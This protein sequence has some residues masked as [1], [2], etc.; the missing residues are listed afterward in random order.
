M[1]TKR[2]NHKLNEELQN[3]QQQQT[4]I[5]VLESKNNTIEELQVHNKP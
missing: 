3:H 2:V 1:V 4:L 5:N